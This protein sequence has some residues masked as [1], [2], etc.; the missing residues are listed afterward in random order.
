MFKV[1]NKDTRKMSMTYSGVF[2]VKVLRGVICK[3]SLVICATHLAS[4]VSLKM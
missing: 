3:R 1:N 2:I 4:G